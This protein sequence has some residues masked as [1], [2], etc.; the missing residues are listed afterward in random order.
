[1]TAPITH[2]DE[3]IMHGRYLELKAA[4]Q[5]VA[6]LVK[7]YQ[8]A[9]DERRKRTNRDFAYFQHEPDLVIAF[10]PRDGA[11]G[12]RMHQGYPFPLHVSSLHDQDSGTD[13]F[14][15]DLYVF[16]QPLREAQFNR[17]REA[18]INFIDWV[19]PSQATGSLGKTRKFESLVFIDL[20]QFAGDS[21]SLLATFDHLKRLIQ[22]DTSE[23][24][25]IN[26]QLGGFTEYTQFSFDALLQHLR[27]VFKRNSIFVVANFID[28]QWK[29]TEQII[30]LIV[31]VQ[32]DARVLVLGSNLLFEGD[33]DRWR[34]YKMAPHDVTI[35]TMCM[36]Q[37]FSKSCEVFGFPPI[38]H[39]DVP[40]T[41]PPSTFAFV[42]PFAGD[43]RKHLTKPAVRAFI[44]AWRKYF[45]SKSRIV[46][47]TG[48][49]GTP[50]DII[51][52]YDLNPEDLTN[53]FFVPANFGDVCEA[54]QEAAIVFSCDSAPVHVAHRFGT[55]CIAAYHSTRW[56]PYSPLSLYHHSPLGFVPSSVLHIPISTSWKQSSALEQISALAMAECIVALL[57]GPSKSLRQTASQIV[58]SFDETPLNSVASMKRTSASLK[59][60]DHWLNCWW[61]YDEIRLCLSGTEHEPKASLLDLARLRSP[62]HKILCR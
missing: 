56:D 2:P 3:Q 1:L 8:V 45:G 36:E 7:Q 25:T 12:F 27:A 14:S 42:N 44:D 28:N 37:Q 50:K 9:F 59:M 19:A 23:A 55:P 26:P 46:F 53:E 5:R 6:S 38:P 29:L 54:I 24:L 33:G 39:V 41:S 16:G 13:A 43:I 51:H 18:S 22:H 61:P 30:R 31:Q 10:R 57:D 11:L 49:H 34:G 32:R 17:F 21:I 4:P 48:N 47:N 15:A 20:F 35:H 62:A 52:F 58:S 40:R 60:T